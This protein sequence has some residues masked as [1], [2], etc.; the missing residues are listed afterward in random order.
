MRLAEKFRLPIVT[1]IDTKGAYPG[2]G[3][4]QRGQAESIARNL[5]EMSRLHTP[6]VCIVIGEGG[7]G[8]ALGIGVGD[9]VAMLQHA[10]YSVISPEGCAAILWKQANERTNE[11]AASALKL[12]ARDNLSNALI[13]AVIEEPPGGAH[14]DPKAAAENLQ[15]WIVDQLNDLTRLKAETLVRRRF[16]K[17]RTIGMVGSLPA[18]AGSEPVPP[19]G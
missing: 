12:T 2:V 7:S 11:L 16:E 13:D 5:L 18:T 8:G 15:D 4:E 10:W 19:L 1:L 17:F 9:R 3:A 14:R 6:I